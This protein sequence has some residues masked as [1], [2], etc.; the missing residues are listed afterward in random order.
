M[1]ITINKLKTLIK[2]NLNLTIIFDYLIGL[3]GM[4]FEK[5][6]KIINL[7]KRINPVILDIGAHKGES[8]KN[9]LRFK[10]KAIIYAFEP[11]QIL[12]LQLKK[13][14]KSNKNIT[15][16]DSAI[17]NENKLNLYIPY[18][19]GYPFSG[20]SSVS[21]KNIIDRL[22][23]FYSFNYKK[24]IVFRNI[25]IKTIVIDK[26]SLKPDLIKIDAEGYE[27]QIVKTA[28]KTINLTKPI[29]IIEFNINSFDELN[30]LLLKLN[31]IGNIYCEENKNYLK[32]INSNL[33]KNIKNQNN[34]VNLIY[35]YKK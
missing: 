6:Y 19:N 12:A 7:I 20:L 29:L 8:I 24:N 34:L 14:F 22:N 3:T 32:K 28:I 18:I 2:S 31:Y 11:N 21:K 4:N 15:I 1:I 35:T 9:F 13:K 25:K 16:F 10:P 5:E 17:S 27:F 30:N 33:L 26:L 23:N